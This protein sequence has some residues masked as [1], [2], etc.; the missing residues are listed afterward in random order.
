MIRPASFAFATIAFAQPSI[1]SKEI[2]YPPSGFVHVPIPSPPISFSRTSSTFSNFGRRIAACFL[3]CSYIPGIS[4][5]NLTWRSW[6]SL[7]CPIVWNFIKFLA[8]SIFA[9]DAASAAIPDPGKETLDVEINLNTISGLPALTH[10]FN[11][12]RITSLLSS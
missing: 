7:S 2:K 1:E 12:S 10:S 11:S 8:S 6:F 3:I 5:K 4:L 9:L